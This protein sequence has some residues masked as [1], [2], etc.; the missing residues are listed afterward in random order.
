[1]R[2]GWIAGAALDTHFTYPLPAEHPLWRMPNVL[3]TPH[4]SG[5]DQSRAFPARMAALF[6]ENVRRYLA[7]RPL[8]NLI[9]PV[10]WHE[11]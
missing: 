2:E 10:E 3:L 5:A 1:M 11:A 4:I 9:S 6:V 8:L 7:G